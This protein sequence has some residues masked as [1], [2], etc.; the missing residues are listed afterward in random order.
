MAKKVTFHLTLL[1]IRSNVQPPKFL[2]F[3]LSRPLL[4]KAC[5]S[6]D[7]NTAR[8]LS[9]FL[10]LSAAKTRRLQR[11]ALQIWC[12]AYAVPLTSQHA[13]KEC[14]GAGAMQIY[15]T[16]RELSPSAYSHAPASRESGLWWLNTFTPPWQNSMWEK[17]GVYVKMCN[18]LDALSLLCLWQLAL[19]KVLQPPPCLE[20]FWEFLSTVVGLFQFLSYSNKLMEVV[21]SVEIAF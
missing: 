17:Y 10:L 13:P 8:V 14:G 6:S 19:L 16:Q 20:S 11:W 1:P 5:P 21:I 7:R 9:D 4:L 15:D 12:T 3:P 18:C 2:T